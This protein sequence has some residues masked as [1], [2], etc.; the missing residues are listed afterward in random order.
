MLVKTASGT[1]YEIRNGRITRHL[2]ADYVGHDAT[3][4][5]NALFTHKSSVLV[6]RPM[7]FRTPEIHDTGVWR[8]SPVTEIV[9]D[10]GLVLDLPDE[11]ITF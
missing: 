1:N 2:P 3:P 11:G 6:G 4:C 7:I 10:G 8:T 9:F 5:E